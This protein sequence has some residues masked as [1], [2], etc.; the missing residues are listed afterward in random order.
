MSAIVLGLLALLPGAA[1]AA[2]PSYESFES[3]GVKK[4]DGIY[5]GPFIEVESDGKEYTKARTAMVHYALIGDAR[6]SKEKWRIKSVAWG[7]G[8]RYIESGG[9]LGG[10]TTAYG[11][12]YHSTGKTIAKVKHFREQLAVQVPVASSGLSEYATARC[13]A[14]R[15]ELENQGVARQAI[16]DQ[17]RDI[18]IS[19]SLH[20]AAR[21]WWKDENDKPLGW[22]E[23]ADGADNIYWRVAHIWDEWPVRCLRAPEPP[24]RVPAESPTP[25]PTVP[26]RLTEA[27]RVTQASLVI[28]PD[29]TAGE[30]P[31][32]LTASAT[33]VTSGPLTVKYRL[34][35]D[36]G[37]LSPV[38]T[39]HVDQT[40]TKFFAIDFSVGQAPGSGS[41][42]PQLASPAAPSSGGPTL[43]TA[44][45]PDDIAKGF[46]RLRIVSPNTL[47]SAPASYLVRCVPVLGESRDD[48][49]KSPDK[50]SPWARAGAAGPTSVAIVPPVSK[51]DLVAKGVVVGGQFIN[52]GGV[53]T[54]RA[55]QAKGFKDGKCVFGVQYRVDNDGQTASA[56]FTSVVKWGG[57]TLAQH[58]QALGPGQHK[59]HFFDAQLEPG[60]NTLS[61]VVDPANAVAESSEA[62]NQRATTVRLLG[63]CGPVV[64]AP[65]SPSP[66]PAAPKAAGVIKLK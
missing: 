32:K 3:I 26:P 66:S 11:H 10:Q 40:H 37:E 59:D 5:P 13:N 39:V 7:I 25:R 46:Y 29:K 30:C 50:P 51:V 47:M 60:T 21:A 38:G 23:A 8:G 15:R 28:V 62:N 9:T 31:M 12:F 43:A 49:P 36:K 33:I 57:A 4:P 42:G 18:K 1:L 19:V 34:E 16:L 52:V 64:K 61:L 54:L 45:T 44:P 24:H 63:P 48:S 27:A 58:V 35:S 55:S 20:F 65:S 41:S 22:A 53:E 14:R 6:V 17:D 56:P 2:Q